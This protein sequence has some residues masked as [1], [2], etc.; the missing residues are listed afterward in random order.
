MR[1]LVIGTLVVTGALFAACDGGS[2]GSSESDGPVP[3]LGDPPARSDPETEDLNPTPEALA[4][5][6]WTAAE[7]PAAGTPEAQALEECL[8]SLHGRPDPVQAPID[9]A[10]ERVVTAG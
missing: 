9:L 8:R 6:G 1:A 7:L 3:R 4:R 2:G 5:C 10:S